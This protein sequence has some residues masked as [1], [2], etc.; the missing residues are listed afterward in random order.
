MVRWIRLVYSEFDDF[1][2]DAE[3]L[4]TQQDDDGDLF[5]F[6][7]GFAFVNS[8]IALIPHNRPSSVICFRTRGVLSLL[9]LCSLLNHQILPL[10]T[11]SLSLCI[12]KTMKN[13]WLVAQRAVAENQESNPI[14]RRVLERLLETESSTKFKR[15]LER[16]P[17]Q[18]QYV[19]KSWCCYFWLVFVT[20]IPSPENT[21]GK[22]KAEIRFFSYY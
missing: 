17:R 9:I 16:L 3:L 10:G 1:T 21:T 12:L 4:V 14:P 11:I 7:E 19:N 18:K 15:L 22:A 20:N 2:Q 13:D 6:V 8:D 5:N